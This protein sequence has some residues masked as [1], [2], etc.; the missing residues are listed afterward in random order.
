MTGLVRRWSAAPAAGLGL[1]L[2][3]A[4]VLLAHATLVASHPAK[5]ARLAAPP[6]SI[7]LEFSETV[8]PATSRVELVA[9]D[10]QRLALPLRQ[11]PSADRVLLADV[12]RLP[13]AGR[14][15]VAWRLVGP[16]G[17]AVTGEF[18]FTVDSVPLAPPSPV[19][20]AAQSS[21]AHGNRD[22]G[23]VAPDAPLQQLARFLTLF[24]VT[25]V[26]GSVVFSRVLAGIRD[27]AGASTSGFGENAQGN[28]RRLVRVGAWIILPVA[29]VRLVSQAVVLGGSLE[30]ARFGDLWGVATASQW[31]F[32][33]FALVAGALFALGAVRTAAGSVQW[34][35]AA[36]AVLLLATSAPLLG[37]AAAAP[38]VPAVAMTLD[39]VHVLAAG[40]WGGGII[41]LAVAVLPAALRLAPAQRGDTLRALLR[42]F[43]PLALTGAGLVA[44]TGAAGALIQL[45]SV[46]ALISTPYGLALIRKLVPVAAVAALGAYHWRVVPP[47]LDA[48]ASASRLRW[49]TALDAA[50]VMAALVLTAILTGTAPPLVSG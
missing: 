49:S 47:S 13:S 3:S 50:L 46:S 36:A 37:H 5:G 6:Q 15:Q 1:V 42:S 10:S 25:L 11:D 40:G 19:P 45:G 39:A 16:D 28:L 12:P 4:T 17:H 7:R 23:A 33:W 21:T 14:Y 22:L 34:A 9:P 20:D 32:G 35:L 8:R 31:G 26:I 48:G 27:A 24:G 29:V 43:T 41:A 44:V 18:D 2:L 30:N 38:R